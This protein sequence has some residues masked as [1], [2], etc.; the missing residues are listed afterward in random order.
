LDGPGKAAMTA[1]AVGKSPACVAIRPAYFGWDPGAIAVAA[2]F[3]YFGY[4]LIYGWVV[5]CLWI[6]PV[7]RAGECG[8]QQANKY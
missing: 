6:L 1:G 3:Y 2:T 5:F 7:I 8:R 4:T